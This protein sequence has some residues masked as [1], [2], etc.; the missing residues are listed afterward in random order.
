VG[1]KSKKQEGG[2]GIFA[3]RA[4]NFWDEIVRGVLD[5]TRSP[6]YYYGRSIFAHHFCIFAPLKLRKIVTFGKRHLFL[7]GA[8]G[9]F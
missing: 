2:M 6:R 5:P 9:S 4:G 1:E 8:R 3:G 7:L